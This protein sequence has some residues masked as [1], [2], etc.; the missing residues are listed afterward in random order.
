MT[1]VTRDTVSWRPCHVGA[2]CDEDGNDPV[3]RI[4]NGNYRVSSGWRLRARRQAALSRTAHEAEIAE[5]VRKGPL[6]QRRLPG[7][8]N[9][10]EDF[11]SLAPSMCAG[12][13]PPVKLIPIHS[14]V[15][16][17]VCGGTLRS[18]HAEGTRKGLSP[19]VRGNRR[20][21]ASSPGRPGSI[22][23]C[24]GEPSLRHCLMIGSIPTF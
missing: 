22:P 23:A 12:E 24:A 19:R 11:L 6:E 3:D 20:D 7:G 21:P 18:A 1:A 16:P 13:P 10:R 9:Q 8:G 17:R 14:R 5:S 15:Y 2:R 4:S